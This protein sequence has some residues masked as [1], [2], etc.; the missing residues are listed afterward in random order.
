[1]ATINVDVDIDDIL[2]DLSDYEKRDLC[3]QLIEDGYAPDSDLFDDVELG[4][5]LQTETYTESELVS[6]IEDLWNNRRFID[7]K[8]V[9][10]LR[11]QLRERNVL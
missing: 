1:M 6:L 9:E 7:H 2:W 10:E 8:L 3:E 11:V 4:D 5:V